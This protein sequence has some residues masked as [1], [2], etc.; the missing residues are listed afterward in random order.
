MQCYVECRYRKNGKCDLEA[1]V[2]DLKEKV[3]VYWP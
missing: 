2:G 1:L 3:D